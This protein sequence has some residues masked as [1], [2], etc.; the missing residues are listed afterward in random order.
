M[1]QFPVLI[2]LFSLLFLANCKKKDPEPVDSEELGALVA[3][4]MERQN[5]AA[6]SVLVF[7][8]E[9][10][11]Y[12]EYFGKSHIGNGTVLTA[13]HPFLI[14]SISKVVTAT[15]LLQLHEQ[16]H[17]GLDDPINDHLPF[18]VDI[19][20]QS[21]SVTFRML[22]THTSAIADGPALDSQYYYNMDSPIALGDF[23]E[24]YL[25][26]GG[27]H[28]NATENFYNFE[29][30]QDHEYSNTGAALIGYLVE[31]ISGQEFN[32]YCK[33]HIFGPLGMD[34]TAWRL[35]EISQT[36]VQ[37]YNYS[38]GDFQLIEHYTFTDYPN[39]G[40]RTTGRD[41]HQFFKL[42][43]AQ[44]QVNGVQVLSAASVEQMMT[45]QIPSLSDDMGLH[46]FLLNSGLNI[47]GHDGGEEGVT[48]VAGVNPATKVG[49]VVLCN[50][51]DADLDKVFESAYQLGIGE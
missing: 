26:P 36:I 11:V 47:W 39:G 9:A 31:E 18:S 25:V 48:T 28:Y 49:V 15:A 16:G 6:M 41:L 44:G 34:N 14:A 43:T 23:L 33:Q 50:A 27:A 8:E 21:T 46:F 1:K 37:P 5:I 7:K 3:D 40:L 22:L 20:G 19:P 42:F 38:G 12:D 45:L 17:F 10:V 4:E 29:P 51:S 35:D 30:G 13:E 24:A 32:A 2:L